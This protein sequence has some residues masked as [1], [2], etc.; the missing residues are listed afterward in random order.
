MRVIWSVSR[1]HKT[2][3]EKDIQTAR[4]KQREREGEHIVQRELTERSCKF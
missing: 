4:D 1:T 2:E 3:I